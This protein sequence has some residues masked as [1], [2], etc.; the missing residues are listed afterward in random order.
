MGLPAPVEP[1]RGQI[2]ITERLPRFLPCPTHLVRQTGD[3]AVQIGESRER[4]GFDDRTRADV[5]AGIARRAIRLFPRLRAWSA[6]RIMTPDGMPLYE[7]SCGHPGAFVANC[8]S[9]VTLA[10]AHCEI[11]APWIVGKT[12]LANIEAFHARRFT[13]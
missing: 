4:A 1:V 10:A 9:G 13:L 5:L 2:M 3:G 7:E 11:I 12:A 8:H 6:L